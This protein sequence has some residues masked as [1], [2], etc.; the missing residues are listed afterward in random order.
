M[1][2]RALRVSLVRESFQ[3]SYFTGEKTEARPTPKVTHVGNNVA[4]VKS[5][6]ARLQRLIFCAMCYFGRSSQ[7]ASLRS[8]CSQH[9]LKATALLG[10]RDAEVNASPSLTLGVRI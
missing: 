5:R 6:S 9:A 3:K 4:W 7:V 8:S 10:T 2:D 1:C